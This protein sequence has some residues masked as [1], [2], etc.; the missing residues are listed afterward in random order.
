MNG[1]TLPKKNEQDLLS[2]IASSIERTSIAGIDTDL[3]HIA[4]RMNIEAVERMSVR[5]KSS[6]VTSIRSF[7]RTPSPV[8]NAVGEYLRTVSLSVSTCALSSS[9]AVEYSEF[10]IMS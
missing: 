1:S 4:I 5:T 3:K 8:I 10:I 2:I 9:V 6:F 7:V